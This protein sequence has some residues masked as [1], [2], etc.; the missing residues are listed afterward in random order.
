MEGLNLAINVNDVFGYIG[1]FYYNVAFAFSI[2]RY[3]IS[4]R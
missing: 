3:S 1:T 2:F 4:L